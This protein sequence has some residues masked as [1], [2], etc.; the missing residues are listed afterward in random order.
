M[1]DA[2]FDRAV[3]DRA[4]GPYTLRRARTEDVAAIVGLLADDRLRSA[5]ESTADGDLAPYLAAF[6]AID[7]AP[8]QLLAVV[9]DPT[10]R[11]VATQQL[12]VLPGLARLG[13]TRLQI[14]AV[15]VSADLRG[16]GLG[17]EMITWAVDYGRARGCRLVQ[18]TSDS[19]RT[20]A[21]RFYRRL[22]FTSSHVGFKLAL[23]IREP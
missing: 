21:H 17:S 20:D 18:L 10:G 7:S 11:V 9:E 16:N 13:A 15:R 3:F 6:A 14:E 8:D 19:S 5:E 1:T 4:G 2:A 23:N 12:T 22:G